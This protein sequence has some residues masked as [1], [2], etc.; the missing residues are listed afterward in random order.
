MVV[1]VDLRANYSVVIVVAP[2]MPSS[3][4]DVQD[5]GSKARSI[6]SE[7]GPMSRS[8]VSTCACMRV[9]SSSNDQLR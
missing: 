7:G 3:S 6:L 1:G 4:R 5:G 9:C 2:G 8:M